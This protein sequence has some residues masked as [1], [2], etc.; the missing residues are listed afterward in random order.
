[1][2]K[3]NVRISVSG[4]KNSLMHLEARK[5]SHPGEA[6]FITYAKVSD[7]RFLYSWQLMHHGSIKAGDGS[8]RPVSHEELARDVQRLIENTFIDESTRYADQADFGLT[9]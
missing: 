8:A 1:M 7:N 5:D 6:L 2:K 3:A 9:N 4:I